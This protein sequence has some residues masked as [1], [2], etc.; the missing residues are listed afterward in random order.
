MIRGLRRRTERGFA[1]VRKGGLVRAPRTIGVGTEGERAIG[2][3][4]KHA[5][6]YSGDGK[7]RWFKAREKLRKRSAGHT[8]G[9]NAV[10][11]I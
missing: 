2:L 10:A 7:K 3:E 8:C 1:P 6:S 4:S 11:E 5:L 9:G